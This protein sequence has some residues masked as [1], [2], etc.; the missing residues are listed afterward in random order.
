MQQGVAAIPKAASTAYQ[1]E[2]MAVFDFALD[3][4]ELRALS[5]LANPAGQVRSGRR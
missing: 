5:V 2:N 4:A 1:L 3:P